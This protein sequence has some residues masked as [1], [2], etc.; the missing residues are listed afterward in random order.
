MI[1]TNCLKSS[2]R[3]DRKLLFRVKSLSPVCGLHTTASCGLHTTASLEKDKAGKY[4]VTVN[5][6]RPL[7]YEMAFRPYEIAIKKGY[8]SFNTAQLV[9]LKTVDGVHFHRDS[10]EEWVLQIF[11]CHFAKNT[12]AHY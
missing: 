5:R 7:T 12:S 2:F 11:S 9:R 8:N 1:V 6:T 10:F 4:Q 3:L